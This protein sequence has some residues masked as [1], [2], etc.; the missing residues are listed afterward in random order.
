M[1]ELDRRDFLKL[2]LTGS[3]M[4]AAGG[5]VATLSGCSGRSEP[6][7]Q[8]YFFLRTADVTLFT[9]LL[10]QLL[11]SM[12]LDAANFSEVLRRI[13]GACVLA[14][15]PAQAQL[16]KLFDLLNTG[17]TRRLTTGVR[18]D[19]SH[20]SAEDIRAFLQRWRNSSIGLF[21]ASYRVLVKLACVSY[22]SLP[23]SRQVSGYPGP[24][25][26]MYQAVNS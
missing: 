5:A 9:A 2:S 1:S 3:A 21:N 15:A 13:D 7:A 18:G 10:P 26:P 11:S 12:P 25:A 16:R 19:W 22:F 6:P 17:L 14:Q 24:W 20:A 4:L 8:G 23:V